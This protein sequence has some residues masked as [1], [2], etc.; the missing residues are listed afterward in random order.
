MADVGPDPM[1]IIQK[2]TYDL[3]SHRAKVE[4]YK[5]EL[6]QAESQRKKT[7][8][9]VQASMRAIEEVEERLKGLIDAHGELPDISAE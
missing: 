2:A 1:V 4:Q 7:K 9:N 3:A 8:E 6:L 5:Y